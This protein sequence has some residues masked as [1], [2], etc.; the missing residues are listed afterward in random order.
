MRKF[1][2]I[3]LVI[4]FLSHEAVAAPHQWRLN[5]RSAGSLLK[6]KRNTVAVIELEANP[7]TGYIWQE[8]L[9]KNGRIRILGRQFI[10]TKPGLIGGAGIERIYV[11]GV[12][13]G[14]AALAFALNRAHA[15]TEALKK[16]NFDFESEGELSEKFEM[17][18]IS[19]PANSE[20]IS[21]DGSTVMREQTYISATNIGVP[22]SFNWCD[23]NGGCTPIKDQGNCGACWA[24]STV[25]VLEN[26]IKIKDNKTTP[27]SE[28]YL[29]S[30]NNEGYSCY[31]GWWAHDYHEW[32][33]AQGESQAGAV[34]QASKPFLG[35][36]GSCNAPNQ[37]VAKIA[38]WGYVGRQNSIPSVD[39]IKQAIY[40]HGP[41]TA[42]VCVNAGFSYYSG[43][44]FSGPSCS[45]VN[46]GVIIVGWN[47]PG[48]Y[49][50]IRNSYGTRWGEN[51]YMRIKYGVSSIGLGA[52]WVDYKG[53]T[54]PAAS[55]N[56]NTSSGQPTTTY[57]CG[58]S[59]SN[60]N[61]GCN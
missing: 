1:W 50:I 25:G 20:A 3:L 41:V 27:L 10:P 55:T 26:L 43:G 21:P 15:R 29:I 46:H 54:T 16:L 57:G 23:Q 58:G 33:T 8:N 60:Y 4:L 35:K 53:S 61:G 31:G 11:A 17:P 56:T 13:K 5:H 37:K 32:K 49:W 19:L 52:T 12:G 47:D 24:F 42:A 34:S 36:N 44:V 14:R 18:K 22:Q 30:C 2:W 39:A 40:D 48:G 38:D 7:S 9:P 6:L 45:R 59:N 51:G 28:Q